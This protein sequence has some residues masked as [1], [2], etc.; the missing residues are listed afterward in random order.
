M[1]YYAVTQMNHGAEHKWIFDEE[2]I[3]REVEQYFNSDEP[4]PNEDEVPFWPISGSDSGYAHI[5]KMNSDE[6]I[7]EFLTAPGDGPD[8][9]DPTLVSLA[10]YYC[11]ADQD[12]N[13]CQTQSHTD[14]F[15]KQFGLERS[16][17]SSDD[18]R[19][20]E[21]KRMIAALQE[22]GYRD[23]DFEDPFYGENRDMRYSDLCALHEMYVEGEA[24]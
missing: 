9:D 14:W 15:M 5:V 7:R 8:L 2:T 23:F 16:Q 19:Y 21:A 1:N 12:D 22:A 4:I 24:R 18:T 17:V 6:E 13:W 11:E 3:A 10:E 20:D